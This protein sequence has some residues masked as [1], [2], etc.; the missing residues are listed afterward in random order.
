MLGKPRPS[1][2]LKGTCWAALF[3]SFGRTHQNL[4][5]IRCDAFAFPKISH[6]KT[7]GFGVGVTG[8]PRVSRKL[9]AEPLG[10]TSLI[11]SAKQSRADREKERRREILRA[12]VTVFAKRGY[13]GCRMADVAR[14]AKVAYGLVY[15]YFE[16]K[17]A[18]LQSVF[19]SGWR[20]FVA[21]IEAGLGEAKSFEAKVRQVI[22]VAF[23]A[24][25]SDPKWVK[26]LILEVGRSP[27]GG[28]V[29]R[30]Q[31]F[32]DII[33]MVAQHFAA[34][35]RNRELPPEADPLLGAS[36]LFGCIEMALTPFVLALLDRYDA[37]VLE[38]AQHQVEVSYLRG[39]LLGAQSPAALLA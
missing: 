26:V 29:N 32:A 4:W 12:A 15:H 28:T 19:D 11:P 6:L 8:K 34:A 5:Y 9:K 25:R 18:L 27:S 37:L 17:D 13:V 22:A 3:A 31:A 24:Y 39:V 2:T 14:E 21:R 36:I 33:S 20:R 23:D 16:D 30:A 38:R 10:G 35:Q 7:N 1:S